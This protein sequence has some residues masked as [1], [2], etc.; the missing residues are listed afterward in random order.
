MSENKIKL[1]NKKDDSKNKKKKIGILGDVPDEF[2]N[3]Y[4]SQLIPYISEDEFNLMLETF[5]ISLPTTFRLSP[6]A[7]DYDKIKEMLNEMV[8][9]LNFSEEEF[10]L[11]DIFDDKYGHIYHMKIDKISFKK[12]KD[13]SFRDWLHNYE[14]LG[15]ISRQEFVSMIPPYFLD[16][17]PE[18]YILDMCSAPGSKTTQITEMM[19]CQVDD[20]YQVP[21]VL[22]A[23]DINANR[24][25]TLSERLQRLSTFQT[26]ITSHPAQQFPSICKFDRIICDVPCTGDGTLRKSPD[27]GDRWNVKNSINCHVLQRSIL[28]N[29]LKLLKVGGRLVYSTCS[30]SPIENESVVNSVLLELKD[31]IKIVDVS[32]LYPKLKRLNGLSSWKV[33]TENGD[34]INSPSEIPENAKEYIKSTMFSEPICDDIKY[35]MRF[36]PHLNNTGGF[37]VAVLEKISEFDIK[38]KDCIR[39]NSEWFEDPFIP[40]DTVEVETDVYSYLMDKFGCSERV[41]KKNLFVRSAESFSSISFANDN[42]S[43]LV[44]DVPIKTLRPFSV[45]TRFFNWNKSF[46]D[47]SVCRVVPCF[48]GSRLAYMCSTKRLVSISKDDMSKLIKEGSNGVKYEEFSESTLSQLKELSYGGIIMYL[49]DTIFSFGAMR[50]REKVILHIKKHKAEYLKFHLAKIT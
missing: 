44:H 7:K 39:P 23:N 18:H 47:P 17:K 11:L 48:E 38:I 2:I 45:G 42:V 5:K 13:Q 6:I 24:I 46:N 27:A 1:E 4:K 28:L 16:I 40:L 20:P 30:L 9:D 37:Y 25:R 41:Q 31:H 15:Y 34:I 35:T 32:A 50:N 26:I 49:K 14:V 3:F 19:Q 22:I 21:G 33:I 8:K 10:K 29:G 43:K 12:S 36:L